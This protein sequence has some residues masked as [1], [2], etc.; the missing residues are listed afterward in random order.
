MT[1]NQIKSFIT[2]VHE[3]SFSKAASALYISQPAISKSIAKMEEELG[4]PLFDH[5]K[6]ELGLT[7]PGKMLYDL[8]THI[9]A[10][11][12]RTLDE[13]HQLL[14]RS[15]ET[16]RIGCPDTWNPERFYSR[17]LDHFHRILPG[18]HVEIEGERLP[19]LLDRLQSGQV[20]CILTYELF[21]SLQ[22]NFIV[23]RLAETDCGIVFSR[24]Y[25]PGV[26]T[27]KDLDQADVLI[28]DVDVEKKFAKTIRKACSEQGFSAN[29]VNCSSFGN[30]WFNMSC[31]KGVMLYT[32]WDNITNGSDYGIIPFHFHVPINLVYMS[33]VSKPGLQTYINELAG[34]FAGTLL[35]AAE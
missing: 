15:E 7:L 30:A 4:F 31:G 13:I 27:L 26:R 16:L 28:F 5:K 33:P 32:G 19:N 2:V 21:R 1:T 8:F 12:S 11:Y 22:D 14:E 29:V 25:R 18:V 9:E 6:G 20:D 34:A 3:N 17:V 24:R 35:T 10:D 23:K